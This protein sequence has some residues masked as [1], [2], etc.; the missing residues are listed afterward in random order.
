M[1][2]RGSRRERDSYHH[3]NLRETL[4]EQ[5]LRFISERGPAGFAFADLARAA[6][7]SPAAPYRH[8]R[9]RNELVAEIARRGFDTLSADLL[10][11]W[12]DGNPDPVTAIERCGHAYLAFARRDT[13]SYAAMFDTALPLEDEPALK[14]AADAAFGVLRRAAEAA[15]AT[16]PGPGRPPALM[17]ALHI[18]AMTHGIASLFVTRPEAARRSLP[19]PPEELLEAGLLIYLQSLGLAAPT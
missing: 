17:V 18:W 7:V 15:C 4:I 9:D 3:G 13:A 5:A 8:F 11:A 16:H 14:Q 2:Y 12:N 1:S 19:M 6:G 10:S